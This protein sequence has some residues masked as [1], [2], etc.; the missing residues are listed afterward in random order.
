MHLEQHTEQSQSFRLDVPL[1][2]LLTKSRML[3]PGL[4]PVGDPEKFPD[5][6]FPEHP[7]LLG[8]IDDDAEWVP[9]ER[10]RRTFL[11]S[12]HTAL[13]ALAEDTVLPQSSKR[14]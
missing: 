4:Q 5:P 8:P 1:H 6:I 14:K 7:E 11:P 12:N 10:L 3:S 9:P 13:A 2:D